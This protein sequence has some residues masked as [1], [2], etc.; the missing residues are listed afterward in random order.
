M[1]PPGLFSVDFRT[2][3]SLRPLCAVRRGGV[4]KPNLIFTEEYGLPGCNVVYFGRSPMF[5][6]NLS[7]PSSGPRIKP[8]KKAD[9]GGKL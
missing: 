2:A 5:R 3:A 6:R 1:V 7:L 8:R 9:P 4:S